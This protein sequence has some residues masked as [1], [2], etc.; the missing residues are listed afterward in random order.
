MEKTKTKKII[1]IVVCVLV[2]ALGF[3]GVYLA[4]NAKKKPKEFDTGLGLSITLTQEFKVES[5]TEAGTYAAATDEMLFMLSKQTFEEVKQLGYNP[6]VMSCKQFAVAL[7][8]TSDSIPLG[9]TASSVK[10]DTENGFANFEY[11]Y[12]LD[13]DAFYTQSYIYRS[14]DA[15]FTVDFTCFREDANK[16]K[17]KFEEFAKS[18]KYNMTEPEAVTAK[19]FETDLGLNISLTNEFN[20]SKDT[21][22]GTYFEL[23]TNQFSTFSVST[24]NKDSFTFVDSTEPTVK[25]YANAFLVDTFE[26]ADCPELQE[27]GNLVYFEVK[28][29]DAQTLASTSV[30]FVFE[31]EDKVYFVNFT[32]YDEI[33][34][35]ALETVKGFAG[36]VTFASVTP[37][38]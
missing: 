38:V 28:E 20:A 13:G 7:I 4:N 36:T 23:T 15:F 30:C 17:N 35:F 5:A 31:N 19:D 25:D 32:S 12:S 9:V 2:F 3:L 22:A 24:K 1:Y 18:A 26:E 14:A 21:V 33:A 8:Y 16:C 11:N 29:E 27:D 10:V 6:D 37:E 34:P